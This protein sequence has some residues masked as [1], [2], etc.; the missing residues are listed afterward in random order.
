MLV[1]YTKYDV[2]VIG[3]G[4]GGMCA[5]ALAAK[6]GYR[7]LV[8]E[9]RD[10]IG[11]RFSTE[12]VDGFKLMTGAPFIHQ[13]GWVPKVC[14]ELGVEFDLSPCLEVS[15]WVRG[16]EYK[17]PLQHRMNAMFEICNR[18]AANKAKLMGN[19]VKEIAS[20]R[21]MKSIHSAIS[22]PE[23]LGSTTIKEWL[24][25]YTDNEDLHG[26]F[27]A[28]AVGMLMAHSYEIPVYNFFHF[29][30]TQKGF[31]DVD[32]STYGNLANMEK[33]AD[34]VKGKGDVWTNCSAK[35]VLVN[36]GMVTSVVIEKDGKEVEVS[37]KAAISNIGI[38]E[39]VQLSGEENFSEDYLADMRV[40]MRPT[41]ITI[42]HIASEQPICMPGGEA[43][44]M[45]VANARR[46][47]DAIPLTNSCPQMAPKG[48]HLT[49]ACASPPSTL[50]PID[51]EEEER[52][53]MK[54]IDMVFPDWKKKG[55][56]ILKLEVRNMDH[57]LPEGRTWLGPAYNMPKDTPVK[58][59]YNV[60][61]AVCSPGIGGTSG[62]AESAKRVIEMI[63]KK[64]KPG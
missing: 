61:D 51:P 28:I 5:G 41:P 45:L 43:G 3:G 36:K 38:R 21:I 60:G 26:I 44:A 55:G 18:I 17:L 58:N 64:V 1:V 59:L 33:L 56:R 27:D 16:E 15:Y 30:A 42:I 52:Q 37:C 35:K 34:A 47:T 57:D 46:I 50:F 53:C 48:Q 11:G 62:C 39:T 7:T 13:S 19:I 23:K 63:K 2:V 4:M 8:A 12:E 49:W 29:M 25:R 20:Q 9:K 32:M 31:N 54:D 10:V 22:D 40:K 24:L 6:A 14:K